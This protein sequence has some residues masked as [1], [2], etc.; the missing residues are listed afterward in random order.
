MIDAQQIQQYH[1]CMLSE[2]HK[3]CLSDNSH[4]ASANDSSTSANS[5]FALGRNSDID[6]LDVYGDVEN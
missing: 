3:D 4:D 6:N 5:F 2:H 1:L